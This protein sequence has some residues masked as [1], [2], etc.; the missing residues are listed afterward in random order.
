MASAR[1]KSA[2]IALAVVGIAGLSLA[3][4]AQL[5]IGASS[6]GA[7][8]SVVSAC[9]AAPIGVT[10]APSAAVGGYNATSVT[11]TGL[12]ATCN[13]LSYKI[14]ATGAAGVLLGTEVSGTTGTGTS[15]TAALAGVKADAVTGISVV[16][17][18]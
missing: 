18:S 12:A 15:L 1:R 6:L 8:A 9:Q 4:A 10:F 2:A 3:S 5:N 16:I 17:Y 13:G 11:L 7:G 14:Q